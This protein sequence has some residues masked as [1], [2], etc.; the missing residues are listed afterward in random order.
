LHYCVD[1]KIFFLG[2]GVL[3]LYWPQVYRFGRFFYWLLLTE[4]GFLKSQR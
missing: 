1:V 2:R 4:T 3:L